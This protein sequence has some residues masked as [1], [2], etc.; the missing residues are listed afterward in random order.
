MA[1]TELM[2]EAPPALCQL[3][4]YKG[5]EGMFACWATVAEMIVKWKN[6]H[7]FFVRPKFESYLA[8]NDGQSRAEYLNFILDWFDS[9]GFVKQNNGGFG[10]WTAD[11]LASH[12]YWRGPLL[13]SGKFAEGL[14]ADQMHD[15]AVY[16]IKHGMIHYI[17]P[18]DATKKTVP[19][20]S[21][22]QKLWSSY[23]AVL[24][25]VTHFR[26]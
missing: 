16:G 6:S 10:A 3:Q 2:L 13:A 23:N 18:M 8:N 19:V 11:E 22:K 24:A 21:F 4:L 7:A 14:E 5:T 26:K 1:V 12:L 20:S 9:F 15:I 17:D 25:R